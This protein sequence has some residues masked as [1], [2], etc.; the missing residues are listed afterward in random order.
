MWEKAFGAFG[1]LG[2]RPVVVNQAAIFTASPGCHDKTRCKQKQR[3]KALREDDDE[4]K[5]R[6]PRLATHG[7]ARHVC[8]PV[9]SECDGP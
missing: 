3:D 7:I 8:H 2:P 1:L 4:G 5:P 9:F 6:K